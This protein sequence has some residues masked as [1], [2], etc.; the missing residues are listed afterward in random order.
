MAHYQIGNLALM[1]REDQKLEVQQATDVVALIGE[2]LAL[3]PKGK[4]FV[5]LCPFHDDSR[6]SMYVS[7]AKQ[8]YKC[9][10]CGAGGDAFSFVMNYHKMTFPE[11]LKHLAQRAGIKLRAFSGSRS[12]GRVDESGERI[13][14]REMIGKAADDPEAAVRFTQV[15]QAYSRLSSDAPEP[16]M[17]DPKPPS[18]W[19]WVGLVLDT[20]AVIYFMSK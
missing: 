1:D 5:C 12:G 7:P 9:F 2:Q 8:I 13:S 4:E 15:S 19:M 16:V 17:N 20:A 11:A 10:S 14:L 18:A 6:P 3:K